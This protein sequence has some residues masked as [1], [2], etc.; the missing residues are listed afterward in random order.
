MQEEIVPLFARSSIAAVA[1]YRVAD[2]A[3]MSPDLVSTA[4]M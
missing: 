3:K 1:N 2:V 4:R